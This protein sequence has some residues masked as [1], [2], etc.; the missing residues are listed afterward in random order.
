VSGGSA[1]REA[2]LSTLR[3]AAHQRAAEFH[4]RRAANFQLAGRTE[5]EVGAAFAAMACWGW[6]CLADRRW[7]GTRSANIDLI[8]VGPGGVLVIDVKA[9]SEPRVVDGLLYRG[10]APAEDELDKLLRITAV[11]EDVTTEAGLAPQFLLP[12][13]VLA[14]R[15]DAA[16]QVGRVRVLGADACPP[17]SDPC[18]HGCP[19]TGPSGCW[20]HWPQR[21]RRTTRRRRRWWL[22]R[23]PSR[24]CLGW[25]PAPGSINCR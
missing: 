11:V 14:G 22:R 1:Y 5:E 10:Q 19:T 12:L 17:G 15:S 8:A 2:E 23:C 9:W 18:R 16:A 21:S 4:R 3:A 20:R 13:I 25:R 6:R 7:P 24:H